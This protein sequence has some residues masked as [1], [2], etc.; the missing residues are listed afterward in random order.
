MGEWENKKS[1]PSCITKVLVLI[2]GL[3]L[4]IHYIP[5]PTMSSGWAMLDFKSW[6]GLIIPRGFKSSVITPNKSLNIIKINKPIGKIIVKK[7]P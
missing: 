4:Q 6:G 7:K 3:K 2:C 1:L 5:N